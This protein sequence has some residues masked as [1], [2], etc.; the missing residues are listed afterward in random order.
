[1][2]PCSSLFFTC[3]PLYWL[4]PHLIF[5]Y[6]VLLCLVL[7]LLRLRSWFRLLAWVSICHHL[8]WSFAFLPDGVFEKPLY[9]APKRIDLV[10]RFLLLPHISFD[11]KQLRTVLKIKSKLLNMA[12]VADEFIDI[13]FYCFMLSQLQETHK[14]EKLTFLPLVFWKDNR[15]SVFWTP[16]P[17]KWGLLIPLFLQNVTNN[18][19]KCFCREGKSLYKRGQK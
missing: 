15:V 11:S 1:M 19:F 14:N 8:R 4:F 16:W 10:P 9:M 3:V 13:L 5:L 17:S 7:H 6:L 2:L 12:Y 18:T